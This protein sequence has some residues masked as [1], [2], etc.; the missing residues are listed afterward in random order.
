MRGVRFSL[1]GLFGAVSFLAVGCGALIY[2]SPLVSKLIF[3]AAIVVLLAAAVLAFCRFG[4]ARAF[5]A[6]FACFGFAYLWLTCGQWQSPDGTVPLRDRL[7][8]TDLLLHCQRALPSNQP[9]AT[10][11]VAGSPVPV[12]GY[13][14][15]VF[16]DAAA[17]SGFSPGY[18]ASMGSSV[19]ATA[20]GPA[21][22]DHS[23][24]LTTG[25]GLFTIAFALLGG[26]IAKHSYRPAR[27]GG[28][29]ASAH[30]RLRE[31]SGPRLAVAA[32]TLLRASAL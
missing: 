3:T 19:V 13:A 25:H 2:A 1:R 24:F 20:A 5:W 29:V 14:V 9:I 12:V 30:R 18:P 4:A 16:F 8:T 10:T 22:V 7:V 21:M 31:K 26:I 11:T 32:T 15:P 17:S 28:R 23:D 6:G 27:C